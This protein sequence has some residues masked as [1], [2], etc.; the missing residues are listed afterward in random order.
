MEKRYQHKD[1]H[2]VWVMLSVSLVR[3][4]SGAPVHFVSQIQDITARKHGEEA[5]RA[6]SATAEAAS[7]AKSEFLANMSHEIRTPMNGILGMTDLILETD[8]T[9]EQRESVGLVKSS[10]DALLTV[11]NDILDFSKIEAGKLDLDP[12]PF[13]LRDTVGDTL[14]ALAARAHAKGLELACD[15]HRDAPD[16]LLGDAHRLRQVLTNLVGNAIKFTERGEVVVRCQRVEEPTGVRLR[17]SVADTGIG[18]APDKLRAV[19]EPF[20]QA[21]GSTTRK[22]GGTGLGLTI[23]QRLVELMDGRIWAES[24][25]GGVSTFF[26]EARLERA[27]GSFERSMEL[28][29][30]LKGLAVLIVD[31]NTTNRRV[32]AETVRHW[33]AKPT[34]AGSGSEALD[35]LRWAATNGAPFPLVLLDGMMPGMD[36]FTVAE[37]IARE[38]ALA[39]TAILMLTSADRQGDAARCRDLGVAAYLVKPVKPAELNRAIGTALRGPGS[40]GIAVKSA[41]RAA[42]APTGRPLRVLVAE[43]NLVNQRV[44]VRLLEK[45]GH[46]VALT[47][48]G[49]QAVSAHAREPFDLVL[50]D[51]QMPEMDGFEA[52]Q[53]IR[54]REAGTG[55]RTPIVAMTAHAMKGDRERCLAA[56]MDDY[57]SKPVQRSELL[58][59]LNGAAGS[60]PASAET[61]APVAPTPPPCDRAPPLD[62]AAAL[63]RLG[64]DEEL[65]AEVAGV[66]LGDAP[67][68]LS[69]LRAA[70]AA[71]DAFAVQRSAH[72]LKGAVGYVGGTPAATAAAALE[73]IGA[74]GAL[75]DAPHALAVLAAEIDRLSSA[76]AQLPSP[77]ALTQ[78]NGTAQ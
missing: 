20:T 55:R 78:R 36:G 1:G 52:T 60:A 51:V 43:D 44:I 2:S 58:R 30:D 18:I 25:R 42:T 10:A 13:S 75:T 62:R 26:F 22:Y 14:K 19:F 11:I 34:C 63:D 66:F 59:V 28:P 46:S 17:F 38:P 8:L 54:T 7:K 57:V 45:Y 56:G 5:L 12:L 23:C 48:D 40:S 70:V 24:L 41:S 50:M 68:L 33:G 4:A 49:A 77:V 74:A 76:L 9:S 69:D 72:G 16:L 35:E 21:D 32:L 3:D 67:K 39:G 27:T 71:G 53:V 37:R 65:F 61:P 31:D 6:A 47:G 64:G 73:K 15:I 29:I